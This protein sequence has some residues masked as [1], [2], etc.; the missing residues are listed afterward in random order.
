[1]WATVTHIVKIGCNNFSL[2]LA[3]ESSVVRP[4]PKRLRPQV[5]WE[6][7]AG[8]LRVCFLRK[9]RILRAGFLGTSTV[10]EMLKNYWTYCAE[11]DISAEH[12]PLDSLVET[13]LK[14]DNRIPARRKM[15]KVTANMR[16]TAAALY[17]PTTQILPRFSETNLMNRQSKSIAVPTPKKEERVKWLNR[18][19]RR[20]KKCSKRELSDK[21]ARTCDE[22]EFLKLL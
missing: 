16:K 21:R 13:T 12:G 5:S 8:L 10:M 22:E 17:T 15:S 4:V 9:N 20:W 6:E 2:S 11:N 3:V 14:V 18:L 7:W 19:E 1:M